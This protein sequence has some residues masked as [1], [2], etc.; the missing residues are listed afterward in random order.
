MAWRVMARVATFEKA[1]MGVDKPLSHQRRYAAAGSTVASAATN[2]AAARA[3]GHF[4][5]RSMCSPIERQPSLHRDDA[6]HSGP[7]SSFDA[8]PAV[9]TLGAA[10]GAAAAAAAARCS[11]RWRWREAARS[12]WAWRAA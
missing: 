7:S 8:P 3:Q 5:V 4:L 1:L 2:A 12:A 6:T 10:A 11:W 9:A